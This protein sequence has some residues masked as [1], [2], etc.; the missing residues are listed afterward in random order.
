MDGVSDTVEHQLGWLLPDRD[1]QPRYF[2]FQLERPPAAATLDHA[3]PAQ[4]EALA[5]AASGL[6]ETQ[7]KQLDILCEILTA[8]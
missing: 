8:S 6:I 1:G 4:L 5:E 3:G 2:R 7:T